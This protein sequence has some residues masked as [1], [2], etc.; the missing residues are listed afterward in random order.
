VQ[1]RAK[2]PPAKR[3]PS[4]PLRRLELMVMT[5]EKVD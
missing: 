3:V 2:S 1:P 4:S 5:P